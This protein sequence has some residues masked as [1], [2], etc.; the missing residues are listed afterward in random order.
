MKSWSIVVLMFLVACTPVQQKP[1]VQDS[2]KT[3]AESDEESPAELSCKH[4]SESLICRPYV[5]GTTVG[6]GYWAGCPD[7]E[8]VNDV[9]LYHKNPW[10]TNSCSNFHPE[11]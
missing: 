10:A 2:A 8:H 7:H 3:L 5:N 1:I 6:T 9:T 11:D 4:D